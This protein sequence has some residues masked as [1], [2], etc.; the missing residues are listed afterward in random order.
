MLIILVIY[1]IA[2]PELVAIIIAVVIMVISTLA[3]SSP[4][5]I[6]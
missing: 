1:F 5:I 2:N 6:R 4:R 3:R